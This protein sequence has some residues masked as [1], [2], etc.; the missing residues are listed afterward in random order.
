M[1][2]VSCLPRSL[3]GLKAEGTLGLC[4]RREEKLLVVGLGAFGI[5]G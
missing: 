1:P 2:A 3:L 5:G 4:A